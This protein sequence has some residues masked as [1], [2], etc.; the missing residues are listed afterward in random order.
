MKIFL[1]VVL[2]FLV[3]AAPIC[4]LMPYEEGSLE[5]SDNAETP[6]MRDEKQDIIKNMAQVREERERN[7]HPFVQVAAFGTESSFDDT[8][9]IN[10]AIKQEEKMPYVKAPIYDSKPNP[11]INFMAVSVILSGFLLAYFFIHPKSK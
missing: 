6:Q 3:S 2:F 7:L 4:A 5:G 9:K 8:S 1:I 11:G 10:S